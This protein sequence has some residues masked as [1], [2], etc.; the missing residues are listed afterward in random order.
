M[1]VIKY[2]SIRTA[3]RGSSSDSYELAVSKS[4]LRRLCERFTVQFCDYVLLRICDESDNT[5]E[6]EYRI[7]DDNRDSTYFAVI[8]RLTGL[9]YDEWRA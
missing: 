3:A 2:V 7:T 6:Y 4:T 9:Y 8:S 5:L 1:K